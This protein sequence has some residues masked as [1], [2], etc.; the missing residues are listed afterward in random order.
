MPPPARKSPIVGSRELTTALQLSVRWRLDARAD[1]RRV[2][3]L[4]RLGRRHAARSWP[5]ARP[6][7]RSTET[8]GLEPGAHAGIRP[9]IEKLLAVTARS[10][11]RQRLTLADRRR[12]SEAKLLGQQ[13]GSMW[14]PE[15]LLPLEQSAQSRSVSSSDPSEFSETHLSLYREQIGSRGR[16]FCAAEFLPT[17]GHRQWKSS[18]SLE[19]HIF[20]LHRLER[21][22]TQ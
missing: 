8:G 3:K 19:V 7:I 13:L 5:G 15:L 16:R 22:R 17:S 6:L 11:N 2:Q 21:A 20:F 1:K 10:Q 18:N 14:L 12:S 4:P 9:H